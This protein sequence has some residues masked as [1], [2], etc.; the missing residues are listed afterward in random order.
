MGC[1]CSRATA[2]LTV[3]RRTR[4]PTGAATRYT[5]TSSAHHNLLPRNVSD[6]LR[7]AAAARGAA[8]AKRC[9]WGSGIR[10]RHALPAASRLCAEVNERHVCTDVRVSLREGAVTGLIMYSCSRDLYTEV[11]SP[12]VHSAPLK[13]R[14]SHTQPSSATTSSIISSIS[15]CTCGGTRY[16]VR[17]DSTRRSSAAFTSDVRK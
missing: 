9:C 17:Y 1:L 11:C 3:R 15:A 2:G 4:L 5:T 14:C 8:A 16:V 12:P 13:G 6:R 10:L 7:V